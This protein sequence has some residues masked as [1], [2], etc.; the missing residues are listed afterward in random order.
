MIR[1]GFFF[2]L[3]FLSLQARAAE[4]CVQ[5]FNAYT[6]AYASGIWDRLDRLGKTLVDEPCEAMQFQELWKESH[7]E[8]I[9]KK[10]VPTMKMIQADSVRKDKAIIGLASGF[11]GDIKSVYSEIFR[12]NN[13]D[14]FFDWIRNLS[15]VQKGFTAI[16]TTLNSANILFLNLHTHPDNETIRSAQLMQMIDYVYNRNQNGSS[17]P[18]ILTGDLNA[19]PGSFEI[20]MLKNLLL[21]KDSFFTANGGYGDTCTYCRENPLSWSNEDRVIDYVLFRSSPE[22][23]LSVQSS[24]VNLKGDANSPLSDHY[25]VRSAMKTT[26]RSTELLPPNHPVVVERLGRAQK[27]LETAITNFESTRNRVYRPVTQM[28]RDL[29]Q[30]LKSDNRPEKIDRALRTL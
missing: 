9:Q 14:G 8:E 22:T 3:F 25:G 7:F 4:F 26:D 21:L 30:N 1:N 15:G 19:T 29:L 12:V 16:E 24:A 28:A 10:L 23:E 20:E 13:E 6:P 11:K 2:V 27:T 5:T 18:I 17:L